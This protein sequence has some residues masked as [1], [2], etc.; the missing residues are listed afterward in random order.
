MK[1]ITSFMIQYK[2]NCVYVYIIVYI[3]SR[4]FDDFVFIYSF[5]CIHDIIKLI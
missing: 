1:V 4:F 2:I 3:I 5:M